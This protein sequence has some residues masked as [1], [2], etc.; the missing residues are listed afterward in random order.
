VHGD[1]LRDSQP[2]E[3]HG[4]IAGGCEQ[5]R[6]SVIYLFSGMNLLFRR[7]GLK[8]IKPRDGP[9]FGSALTGPTLMETKHASVTFATILD[10]FRDDAR[11]KRDLGDRFERLMARY[12]ELDPIH[13]D[14]FYKIWMWNDWRGKGK[15][16]DVGTDLV[17]QERA[18]GDYGAIQ[19]KFYLPEHTLS[20]EDIDSF[21]RAAGR[22]PFT[23]SIIVSTTDKWGKNAQDALN[24]TQKVTRIGIHDLEQN[25]IDWSKFD[26]RRPEKLVRK[27]GRCRGGGGQTDERA[28]QSRQ[29]D[30]IRHSRTC[31]AELFLR[32]P[33]KGRM[34]R[35]FRTMHW[36]WRRSR[37]RNRPWRFQGSSEPRPNSP[38]SNHCMVNQHYTG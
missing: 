11:S 33:F 12:F 38:W 22:D 14:C 8:P 13:A 21:F 1:A 2:H 35:R 15:V 34:R 16:G 18:T 9:V 37:K 17:G 20:K 27:P 29:P 7:I 10:Q 31:G 25:P 3:V 6:E 24:Q 26:A 4:G 23:T 28:I 36:V 5:H 30:R 32:P 19:C